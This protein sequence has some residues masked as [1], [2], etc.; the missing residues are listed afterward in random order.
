MS[1][2]SGMEDCAFNT[3]C[4][5]LQHFDIHS[6]DTDA[7]GEADSS[8][9]SETFNFDEGVYINASSQTEDTIPPNTCTQLLTSPSHLFDAAI[10]GS[11]RQIASAF[12]SLRLALAAS[13][14]Q[15]WSSE[16][17]V[18]LPADLPSD[19]GSN[20][21]LS[22]Y[23][24][25][26]I[27]I[28]LQLM[29]FQYAFAEA[30]EYLE[31]GWAAEDVVKGVFIEKPLDDDHEACMRLTNVCMFLG[32]CKTVEVYSPFCTSVSEINQEEAIDAIRDHLYASKCPQ[33]DQ[34]EVMSS[35][36]SNFSKTIAIP[37]LEFVALQAGDC[38]A[39]APFWNDEIHS[40]LQN[41]A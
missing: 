16:E 7:E 20:E 24:E 32:L 37:F 27:P 38:D 14:E 17:L 12:S 1:D 36:T 41:P 33:S 23:S 31:E 13:D 25:T 35:V 22:A 5:T 26:F 9:A 40:I 29:G 21:G 2:G 34:M 3:S 8:L 28:R 11:I 30:M 19:I 10:A 18:I 4:S 15:T 39:I 6:N